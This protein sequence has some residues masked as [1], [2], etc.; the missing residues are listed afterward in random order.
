MLYRS[1]R[2]GFNKSCMLLGTEVMVN[3]VNIRMRDRGS[4]NSYRAD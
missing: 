3:K 1:L 4:C 2:G